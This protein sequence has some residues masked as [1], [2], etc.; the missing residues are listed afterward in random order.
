[1]KEKIAVKVFNCI[2]SKSIRKIPVYS[3]RVKELSIL[4]FLETPSV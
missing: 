3:G 2:K 4:A 1:M